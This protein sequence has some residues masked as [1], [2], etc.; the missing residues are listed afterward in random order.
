MAEKKRFN[1]DNYSGTRAERVRK[2]MDELVQARMT[3]EVEIFTAYQKFRFTM[4]NGNLVKTNSVCSYA[5]IIAHF[6]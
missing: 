3:G 1:M 5:D 2:I 6:E 4:T